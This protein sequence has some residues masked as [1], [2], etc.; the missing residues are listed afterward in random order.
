MNKE[1]VSLSYQD[2]FSI[3]F[4]RFFQDRESAAETV[5]FSGIAK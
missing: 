1:G 2:F 4:L 3:S 5:S